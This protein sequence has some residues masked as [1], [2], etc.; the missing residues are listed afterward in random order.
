MASSCHWLLCILLYLFIQLFIRSFSYVRAVFVSWALA[1]QFSISLSLR[2]QVRC[3]ALIRSVALSPQSSP[4]RSARR[5]AHVHFK[6]CRDTIKQQRSFTFTLFRTPVSSISASPS[7]SPLLIY[8][9]SF[10][11]LFNCFDSEMSCRPCF[12]PDPFKIQAA[13]NA[14]V[15]RAFLRSD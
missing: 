8:C 12:R 5:C 4:P 15:P 9:P 10:P 11:L 2:L 1:F 6:V 3:D 13:H 14:Q 7:F